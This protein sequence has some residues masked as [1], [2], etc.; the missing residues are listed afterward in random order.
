M[1]LCMH[2]CWHIFKAKFLLIVSILS[3]TMINTTNIINMKANDNR[4]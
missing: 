4:N 3:N 1:Y 2:E